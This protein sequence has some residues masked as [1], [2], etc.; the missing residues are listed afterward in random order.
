[1]PPFGKFRMALQGYGTARELQNMFRIDRV[2]DEGRLAFPNLEKTQYIFGDL[3]IMPDPRKPGI[4][5]PP[6]STH[7]LYF[8]LYYLY[9]PPHREQNPPAPL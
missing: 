8:L 9:Y 3:R 5:R 2:V 6:P 4:S 7:L 1:M